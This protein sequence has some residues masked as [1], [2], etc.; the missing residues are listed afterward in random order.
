MEQ[1]ILY[2]CP[3]EKERIGKNND[4]GYSVAKLPGEYDIF[5][6]GGIS[7]DITFEIDFLSKNKD[8]MCYAF[9]GTVNSL[10]CSHDRI[11]FIKKNLGN[12]NTNDLTNL[13]DYMK[14]YRNIFMK[15]DIEG[16]EFV[17]LPTM[18]EN[19]YIY[20]VKQLVLEIHSPADIQLY[21]DYFKGLSH[22]KNENMFNLLK[23]LNET[24]TLIHFHANNGCKMNKID[25]I[26]IPHVFEVTYIRNDF[27]IEKIKNREPLPTK[28]DMPNIGDK[29]EYSLEGFPYSTTLSH[30]FV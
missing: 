13:Y 10:P 21:P 6:S 18:F 26:N 4:G 27:V 11:R 9:D 3:F 12:V 16:H 25:G 22:I 5:L 1:L 14:D 2:T 8:L 30:T 29:T 15:M 20:K 17:I 24:H 23:K 7:N 19:N 28:L